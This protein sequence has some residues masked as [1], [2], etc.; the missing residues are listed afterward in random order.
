MSKPTTFFL[1]LDIGALEVDVF[2]EQDDAQQSFGFLCQAC[3][4]FHCVLVHIYED[5]EAVAN[6][7]K[8]AVV[9]WTTVFVPDGHVDHRSAFAGHGN[10]PKDAGKRGHWTTDPAR[11]GKHGLPKC[12]ALE[13]RLEEYADDG[14]DPGGDGA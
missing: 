3:H 13:R 10:I 4:G 1:Q 14:E 6:G 11:N 7:A 2:T 9:E 12:I 8:V 5:V